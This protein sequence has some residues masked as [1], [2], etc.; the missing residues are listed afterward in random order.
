MIPFFIEDANGLTVGEGVVFGYSQPVVNWRT[1]GIGVYRSVSALK[2]SMPEGYV[3]TEESEF[4]GRDVIEAAKEFHRLA[5]SKRMRGNSDMCMHC[6][7]DARIAH[8]T[9]CPYLAGEAAFIKAL[10]L[11]VSSED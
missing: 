3:I 7:Q 10:A 6:H 2:A 1:G 8:A 9:A 4:A 5:G 11:R